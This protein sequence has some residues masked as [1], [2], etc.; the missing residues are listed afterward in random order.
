MEILPLYFLTAML[1][2]FIVLYLT[3]P[4]PQIILK[5]PSIKN[6][7]SDVYVDDNNVCYRYHKKEIKCNNL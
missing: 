3:K 2:T 5:Y 7:V 1:V 6:K 4:T